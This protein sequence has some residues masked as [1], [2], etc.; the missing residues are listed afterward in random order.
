MAN[1]EQYKLY[2]GEIILDFQTIE[3]DLRLIYA[4]M[5]KGDFEENCAFVK[6]M[7]GIGTV[8]K[9]LR[10]LDNSDNRPYFNNK[11]YDY[12][13]KIADKR[14]HYCHQCFLDFIYIENFE[15]SREFKKSFD[16]LVKDCDEV[17]KIYRTV[18]QNR[19]KVLRM[20]NRID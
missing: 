18:E 20:Y 7:P 6:K 10:E 14:N 1:L 2:L 15:N 3:S 17:S 5:L 13:S 9:N 11:E 12:L 8:V 16:Q 4:G 19:L